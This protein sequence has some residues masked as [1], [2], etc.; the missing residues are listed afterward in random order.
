MKFKFKISTPPALNSTFHLEKSHKHPRLNSGH[1]HARC[2]LHNA[3][4]ENTIGNFLIP[5]LVIA[6]FYCDSIDH[7]LHFVSEIPQADDIVRKTGN[8]FL[9]REVGEVPIQM[10]REGHVL[11]GKEGKVED[12]KLKCSRRNEMF[13]FGAA[14]HVY[15][16]GRGAM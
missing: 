14:T 9:F 1:H 4:P 3:A 16:R 15:S 5:V 12:P 2:A 11:C 8:M 6:L 10:P 7:I 13:Q